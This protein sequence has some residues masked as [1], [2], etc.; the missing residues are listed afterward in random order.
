MQIFYCD[1]CGK[2]IPQAQLDNGQALRLGDDKLAC[3]DCAQHTASRPAARAQAKSSSI[4]LDAVHSVK[5][6][7]SSGTLVP[8]RRPTRESGGS[9]DRHGGHGHGA[10]GAKGAAPASPAKLYA[11]IA[12]GF[13]VVLLGVLFASG[14]SKKI[15]ADHREA[16]DIPKAKAET[17]PS[18]L[19]AKGP[20][21][22][23]PPG[24]TPAAPPTPATRTVP[25]PATL[26]PAQ[27]PAEDR[28]DQAADAFDT[29]KKFEGLAEDDKEGRKQKIESFLETYGDTMPG[30]RARVLLQNLESGLSAD[31][32][33]DAPEPVETQNAEK[34]AHEP[35]VQISSATDGTVTLVAYLT[36]GEDAGW[37]DLSKGILRSPS[38]F[39]N[40][41]NPYPGQ[42]A[43]LRFAGLP[44]PP[45]AK[46]LE[47]RIQ[48]ACKFTNGGNEK[49]EV[50]SSIEVEAADHS[51]P[52]ASVDFV[53]RERLKPAIA[54]TV[55]WWT[56]VGERGPDQCTPD[57]SPLV[58]QVVNRPGW[59]KDSAITFLFHNGARR[60]AWGTLKASK[61]KQ[62]QLTIRYRE[63][64]EDAAAT[65]ESATVPETPAVTG[66]A[67]LLQVLAALA[68]ALHNGEFEDAAE[69]VDAL[70]KDPK[71]AGA[72]AI[73]AR[74]KRDL[75]AV[76]ALREAAIASLNEGGKP[77]KLSK[78][79]L[80]LEGKTVRGTD[81]TKV[82]VRI[83]GG[84]EMVVYARDFSA[85][86]I[87][88]YAPQPRTADER[89]AHAYL[90][91][92][93]GDAVQAKAILVEAGKN[94]DP[95]LQPYLDRLGLASLDPPSQK[96]KAAW[97]K[98]EQLFAERNYAE[99]NAEVKAFKNAYGDTAFAKE[100]AAA[101]TARADAVYKLLNPYLPGLKGEY[102]KNGEFKPEEKCKERID[103]KIEFRWLRAPMDGV[104]ENFN[105]RWT[106]LLKVPER[107]TY[108]LFVAVDDGTRLW[109]DNKLLIDQWRSGPERKFNGTADLDEGY[110]NLRLDFYDVSGL[111]ACT[112]LWSRKDGFAE[113]IVPPEAL[114]HRNESAPQT[115]AAGSASAGSS[116]A[117]ANELKPVA[118]APGEGAFLCN[119]P[120]LDVSV[121][122]KLGNDGTLGYNP[123]KIVV[124]GVESPHGLSTAPN[125]GKTGGTVSFDLGGKYRT[126]M[127]YGAINFTNQPPEPL[128]FSV[129]LDGKTAWTSRPL[130]KRNEHEA[131]TLDV[132]GVNRLELHVN[133]TG[134]VG[135]AHA[136][137][138]EPRVL[139]RSASAPPNPAPAAEPAQ[140]YLSNLPEQE[141]SVVAN[142]KFGKRGQTG[143]PAGDKNTKI[144]VAGFESPNGLCLHPP[145]NGKSHVAYK[146]DKKYRTF[147]ARVGLNDSSANLAAAPV[148]FKI[149]GDGK[150]LWQSKSIQKAGMYDGCN[151]TITGV[152][153]LELEVE[154]RGDSS[155]CHAVWIEPLLSR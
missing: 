86:E 4:R 2:R 26:P 34:G 48:F 103:A 43:F 136:V 44:I 139:A 10:H 125:L 150:V 62:P 6:P 53:S 99:V 152:D 54:W 128:I 15:E 141:V 59:K 100:N 40:V 76:L 94:G 14:G 140:V 134:R 113:Q 39:L 5:N 9:H 143:A 111:G 93:T 50:F 37:N 138:F 57:L 145:N 71:F 122:G 52:I 1:Q 42:V 112:L 41:S 22:L 106:G 58:Q 87:A 72:S 132:T 30:A 130:G 155:R 126:F 107:G 90:H 8:Y 28:E 24:R 3:S 147:S 29:L 95:D 75:V 116:A 31:D 133:P 12:I 47:A 51:E 81:N 80:N 61:P 120:A 13:V 117:G 118:L 104:P 102:F 35:P 63:A 96:A 49:K 19:P 21:I 110:H 144:L 153:K 83:T 17:A 137:W 105:V 64:G 78:G 154:C 77:V 127:T 79:N 25:A 16:A 149:L 60:S 135:G 73:L 70:L 65:P 148:I 7:S 92:A 142:W 88:R 66:D 38:T 114:W 36:Q 119:L 11:G 67:N 68:P 151:L 98:V 146:I 74:E 20:Q 69:R 121:Y 89:R 85:A 18:P 91:L 124:D 27:D 46:I 56:V 97:L 131:C 32:P 123:N 129:T 115:P 45:Q 82:T 84:P 55:P 101:I 109:I 23:T 108:T 33:D